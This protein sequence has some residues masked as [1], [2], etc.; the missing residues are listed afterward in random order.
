MTSPGSY[1][2][3]RPRMHERTAPRL[4]QIFLREDQYA[5]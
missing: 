2:E 5:A 1:G 3:R 4:L